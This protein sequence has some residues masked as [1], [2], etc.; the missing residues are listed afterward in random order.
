MGICIPK[1]F[2]VGRG[3]R[4][5]RIA[6]RHE[7]QPGTVAVDQVFVLFPTLLCETLKNLCSFHGRMLE[8]II[9]PKSGIRL[10]DANN[11]FS[12][13][14]NNPFGN[15]IAFNFLRNRWNDIDR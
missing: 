10:Q 2:A 7:L 12:Y 14:A 8:M 11:L 4:E 13:V 9:D 3:Q 15:F 1:I 6:E 5:E